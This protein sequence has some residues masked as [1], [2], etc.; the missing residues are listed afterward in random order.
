MPATATLMKLLNTVEDTS[1]KGVTDMDYGMLPPEINSGRM[2]AGPGPGSILS[3]ATAWGS[4]ATDLQITATAYQAVVAGLVG[5][6]WLGPASVALAAAA[7]PYVSWLQNSTALADSAAAQ[8][9][10]AAAAH[11]AAFAMTVPP[12]MVVANRALLVALVATNFLGQNTPA[13]AATE[14][15]YGQMW[16]QDAVAMYGYAASASAA[17][18]LTDFESAPQVATPS[19]LVQQE[20]AAAAA[21][22]GNAQT[23]VED[24]LAKVTSAIPATLQSLGLPAVPTSIDQ[25]MAFYGKFITPFMPVVTNSAQATS[26]VTAVS[27][28]MKGLAPA[29]ASAA[30]AL[31]GSVHALGAAAGAGMRGAGAGV[32]AELGRAVPVGG[33][34]VPA[35]WASAAPP[36]SP[37][38]AMSTGLTVPSAAAEA[39][40]GGA[41][42]G[43]P[44]ARM[45]QSAGQFGGAVPRYGFRH[46]VMARPFAAG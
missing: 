11:E 26:A 20:A 22:V 44:L 14:A 41:T 9:H 5:G 25:A 33:L 19:G 45:G 35:S 27:S 30:K 21:A 8:A 18:E 38:S 37:A 1:K 10:A 16:A 39:G 15:E 23:A 24:V 34:S 29:A 40:V 43:A 42:V 13:I 6:P 46:A 36:A 7:A 32:A 4:L 12:P 31:E 3:A 2:Y 17:T 28:F